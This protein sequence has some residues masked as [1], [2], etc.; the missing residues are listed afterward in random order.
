MLDQEKKNL[1][2]LKVS[3]NADR[4]EITKA[5]TNI[6]KLQEQLRQMHGEVSGR[7][8]VSLSVACPKYYS[9]IS[10]EFLY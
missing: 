2:N 6:L 3:N 9:I 1:E 4:S 7:V 8:V 10:K 5:E